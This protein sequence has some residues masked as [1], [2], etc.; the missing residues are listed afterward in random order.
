[1]F[2]HGASVN[3]YGYPGYY[4]RGYGYGYGGPYY[5]PA[6]NGYRNTY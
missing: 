4:Q 1:M 6:N 2:G 3:G 5:G